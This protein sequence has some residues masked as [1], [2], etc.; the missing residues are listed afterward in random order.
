MKKR[1]RYELTNKVYTSPYYLVGSESF[2]VVIT[3]YPNMVY[4]I[5]DD[6]GTPI[7]Y[8]HANSV[9]MC[10]VNSKAILKKIG[11]VFEEETRRSND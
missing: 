5:E 3:P 4:W 8:G 9:R 11:V 1:V 10:K 7:H 6:E 2:R